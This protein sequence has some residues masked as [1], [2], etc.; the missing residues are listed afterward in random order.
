MQRL[1]SFAL[2]STGNSTSVTNPDV[3][4]VEGDTLVLQAQGGNPAESS[5]MMFV[6]GAHKYEISARIECD[7]AAVAGLILYYN[8]RFY[9]GTGDRHNRQ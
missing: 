4:C 8:D 7:S 2:A 9:V 6:T 5:P 3:Q 1:M